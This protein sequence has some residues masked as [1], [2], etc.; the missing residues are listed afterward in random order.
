MG[1]SWGSLLGLELAHRRPD[2]V[3]AYVGTGQISNMAESQRLSYAYALDKAKARQQACELALVEARQQL[4]AEEEKLAARRRD[5]QKITQQIADECDKSMTDARDGAAGALVAQR[6]K[7]ID[8]LRKRL[9]AAELAVVEQ[10]KQVQWAE[11]RV[12]LRRTEL[13]E[14][15]SAVDA[16]EKYREKRQ[17]EF[18]AG[19]QKAEEREIDDTT[20]LRWKP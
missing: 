17:R 5:V 4:A 12:E 2:L 14:A 10:V 7:F 13:S 15:M 3:A 18:K 11:Q 9:E 1:L 16:L 6:R 19:Q 8:A 20:S